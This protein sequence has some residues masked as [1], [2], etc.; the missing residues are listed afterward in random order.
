MANYNTLSRNIAKFPASLA[1]FRRFLPEHVRNILCMQAELVHLAGLLEINIAFDSNSDDEKR[2]QYDVNINALKG[3]HE[4]P[5]DAE[6]WRMTLEL[7]R[8]L[9]EYDEALLMLA[10]LFRLAPVSSEDLSCL[11]DLLHSPLE[12]GKPFLQD[13]E[14]FT[15]SKENQADLTSLMGSDGE[16]DM[17]TKWV[18]KFVRTVYH[19]YIGHRF[20][21]PISVCEAG[22]EH[23]GEAFLT[24]YSDGFITNVIDTLSTILSSV[25]PTISALVLFFINDPLMRMIALI[26]C[27]LLFSTT[28][29][30]IGRASRAECFAASAAFTAVLVVFLGT[31]NGSAAS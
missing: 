3:P 22:G 24:Y 7:R 12:R 19:T 25:L 20:H 1:I 27:T 6:Q 9:K 21:D 10:N 8:L 26:G 16:K 5:A 4:D 29:A 23:G 28:L 11:Q 13:F 15:Y 14:F 17:L 30:L 31:S 18:D 2:R